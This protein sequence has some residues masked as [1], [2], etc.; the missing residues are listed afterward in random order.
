MPRENT[1]IYI[2]EDLTQLRNKLFYDARRMRK[3][4]KIQA[5]WTQDGNII[6]KRTSSSEPEVIKTHGDL[7][8]SMYQDDAAEFTN[9]DNVD[10]TD[11]D[12]NYSY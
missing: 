10:D 8:N 11:F 2:N 5:V 6:I 4:E 12:S 9:D 7:R 3:S 1:P